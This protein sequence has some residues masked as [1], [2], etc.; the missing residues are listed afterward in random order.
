MGGWMLINRRKPNVGAAF[1]GYLIPFEMPVL[2][3]QG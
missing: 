2:L 3:T 1:K